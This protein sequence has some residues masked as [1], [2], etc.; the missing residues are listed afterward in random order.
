M[1]KFGVLDELVLWI[2]PISHIVGLSLFFFFLG[3]LQHN[4]YWKIGKSTLKTWSIFGGIDSIQTSRGEE[5]LALLVKACVIVLP[6]L[7]IWE[8]NQLLREFTKDKVSGT[9][10]PINDFN[11]SLF[12]REFMIVLE[13]PSKMEFSKPSSCTSMIT[14]LAARSST[15]STEEG[16][17]NFSAREAITSPLEFQIITP[18]PA[19]SDSPNIT[20]SKFVL[21]ILAKG[22][23]IWCSSFLQ[24]C[25]VLVPD[26]YVVRYW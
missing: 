20:P 18:I 10:W 7:P 11:W 1:S 15:V 24:V 2:H 17:K 26:W 9:K 13:S 19:S 3:N 23:S 16:F 4:F 14:R 21:Y 25:L 12:Q 6:C 22:V 8:N 5:S